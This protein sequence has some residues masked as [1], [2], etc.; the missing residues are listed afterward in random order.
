MHCVELPW[1]LWARH[2]ERDLIPVC[3]DHGAVVVAASPLAGGLLTGAARRPADPGPPG[4]ARPTAEQ[5]ERDSA[6][7]DALRLLAEAKGCTVGQLAL[8]WLSAMGHRKWLRGVVPVPTTASLAHLRDNVGAAAVELTEAEL[9]QI[10][11]VFPAEG[12]A[13]LGCAPPPGATV[14]DG[15]TTVSPGE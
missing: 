2:A 3:R 7:V 1:S 6:R 15:V 13:A 10:N 4:A 14:L 8:A 9:K 12:T 11:G 5:F